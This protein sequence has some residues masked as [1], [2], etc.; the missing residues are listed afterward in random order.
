MERHPDGGMYS[1]KQVHPG[2]LNYKLFMPDTNNDGRVRLMNFSDQGRTPALAASIRP[3]HRALVYVTRPVKKFIWAIEYTG[4]VHEGQQ[5]ASAYQGQSDMLPSESEWCRTLLP[6]RFLATIDVDTAPDSQVVLD[7]AGV[8]FTPNAFPM[9][10]ISA[11]EY[12]KIFE[13]IKWQWVAPTGH[14]AV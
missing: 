8:T 4:T 12:Q 5:A 14:V 10:H 6:I 3:N 11:A 7:Q 2:H 1:I 13:A 9:K